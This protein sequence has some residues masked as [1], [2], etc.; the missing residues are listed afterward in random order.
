[1]ENSSI[2]QKFLSAAQETYSLYWNRLILYQV[3]CWCH[4]QPTQITS[5][6]K[7]SVGELAAIQFSLSQSGNWNALQ[8]YYE[9]WAYIFSEKS[10]FVIHNQSIMQEKWLLRKDDDL[11]GILDASMLW[12]ITD[13]EFHI[14]YRKAFNYFQRAAHMELLVSLHLPRSIWHNYLVS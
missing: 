10:F 4:L 3:W 11:I 5:T 14:I 7:Y 13:N 8:G 12:G 1:M 6:N 2:F 9:V